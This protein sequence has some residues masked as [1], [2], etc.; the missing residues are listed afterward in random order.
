MTS[1][2]GRLRHPFSSQ[3]FQAQTEKNAKS[4]H[5]F[6]M[7]G[8]TIKINGPRD[9]WTN[10]MHT[11]IS[12]WKIEIYERNTQSKHVI[13]QKMIKILPELWQKHV[14]NTPP[15]LSRLWNR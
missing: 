10:G 14:K 11:I 13:S 12:P 15:L 7:D 4:L 6:E 1:L 3:I 8:W 2:G 5:F 9:E